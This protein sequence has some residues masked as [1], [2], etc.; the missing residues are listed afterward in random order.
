MDRTGGCACGAIRFNIT[1]PF[2]GVGT[3]HCTN[4]QKASGGGPNYVALT[5]KDALDVIQ[6]EPTLFETTGDSGAVVNRAF[7]GTCGT[8]LWGVPTHE[9]FLTVKLGALDDSAD[10]EPQIQIYVSS[11]PEWHA[12]NDE[13]PK[14]PKM[15]PAG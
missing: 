8:P 9:P 14:F 3:C 11:A 13:F 1:A 6:G 15:P 10:L 7:C 5:P 2:L 12:I 4:C